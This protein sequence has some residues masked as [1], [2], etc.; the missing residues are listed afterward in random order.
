ME[1]KY[2]YKILP[3]FRLIIS[4]YSGKI[5]E[6]EIISLK[7]TIKGD[8]AYNKEYN[9]LDDFS[10]TDFNITNESFTRVL[11]WLKDN[12]SAD[13][14]SAVLTRTPNQVANIMKFK[15]QKDARL[16]MR[17]KIFSTLLAA[18]NWVE[19]AVN[20]TSEIEKILEE[21]RT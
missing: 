19:V 12:Y 14:N 5:S 21:L 16:P 20:Q 7:E 17:I 13:R 2:K 9:I 1:S 4:C 3:E 18:L 10:D 6:N 8:K 11:Y 15:A